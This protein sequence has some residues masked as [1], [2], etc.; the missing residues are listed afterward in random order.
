[1]FSGGSAG[2]VGNGVAVGDSVSIGVDVG[3]SCCGVLVLIG[4][5]EGVAAIGVADGSGVGI[6]GQ[7]TFAATTAPKALTMADVST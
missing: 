2:S 1:M 7:Y 3:V 6:L 4:V 5:D